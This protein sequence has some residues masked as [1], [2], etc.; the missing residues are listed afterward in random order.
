MPYDDSWARKC[1]KQVKPAGIEAVKSGAL[2][3]KVDG[4]ASGQV[5]EWQ[6]FTGPIS[7]PIMHAHMHDVEELNSWAYAAD[8]FRSKWFMYSH[9]SAYWGRQIVNFDSLSDCGIGADYNCHRLFDDRT[10][11][12]KYAALLRRWP[13]R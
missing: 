1:L 9:W 6:L 11:A 7:T 4:F 2:L 12:E 5:Q 3:F 8:D 10:E 13:N